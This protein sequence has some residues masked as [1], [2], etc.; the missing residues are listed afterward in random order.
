MKIIGII[1]ARGGSKGVPRKN[2]KLLNGKPLIYYSIK[3][4]LESHYISDVIVSTDDQE[5]ATISE[6]LGAEVIMRPSNLAQDNSLVIDTIKHV[7]Q[8]K[9]QSGENCDYIVLLE[10]TSPLRNKDDID[11]TIQCVIDENADSGATF[12]ETKTPPTRLWKINSG[13]PQPFIKGSDPFFPRQNHEIGYY[14][15]GMVYV[16]KTSELMNQKGPSI[17]PG[18]MIAH[19]IPESRVIDIDSPFDFK[20]AEFLM[21]SIIN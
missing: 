10:P 13:I 18:K 1:P 16:I 2:V 12:S 21:S 15:N 8:F 5:I 20:Q 19:I 4:G 14:L 17:L 6:E 7:V 9:L 11:R 3:A